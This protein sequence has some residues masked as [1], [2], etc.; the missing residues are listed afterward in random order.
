MKYI[1]TLKID[2]DKKNF[3]VIP[4][5][6]YDNNTRFLHIQLLN[7][8]VPFDITG[9]SVILSGVKE[10]GNPIFNSCDIINSEIG[11]IQAEVTEQM[12]AIPGYIDCEIKIYDG[13]GVLTSKK[14]TIKVTA[15][16]TSREVESSGEFKALT[17]AVNKV[18]SIGNKMDRGESIKVSQIDKNSGKLDQTYM[19]EEFLR[20]MAGNTPIN[21][22]PADGSLTTSKYADESITKNKI[23]KEISLHS[24][25]LIDTRIIQHPDKYSTSNI[26]CHGGKV[27]RTLK[28]EGNPVFDGVDYSIRFTPSESN[29]YVWVADLKNIGLTELEYEN[30]GR[31]LTFSMIYSYEGT[32]PLKLQGRLYYTDGST[33]A[34]DYGSILEIG[35]NKIL[36]VDI[37]SE[38]AITH[39][40]LHVIV[41]NG[42]YLDFSKPMC[43]YGHAINDSLYKDKVQKEIDVINEDILDINSTINHVITSKNWSRYTDGIYDGTGTA[44]INTGDYSY[45]GN[46]VLEDFINAKGNNNWV[47][48]DKGSTTNAT[49]FVQLVIDRDMFRKIQEDYRNGKYLDDAY[50]EMEIIID[51]EEGLLID[52][53]P[54]GRPSNGWVYFRNH[55]I[56]HEGGGKVKYYKKMYIESSYLKNYTFDDFSYMAVYVLCKKNCVQSM[57]IGQYENKYESSINSSY[58]IVNTDNLKDNSV[59]Y[60]KLS[61][62]VQN[63]LAGIGKNSDNFKSKKV[64]YVGDSV[65]WGDGGLNDGYLGV[66][67]ESIRKNMMKSVLIDDVSISGERKIISSPKFYAGKAV[68]VTGINSYIEFDIDSD[69]LHLCLCKDRKNIDAAICELYADDKLIDTFSTYNELKYGTKVKT[70]SS[71]GVQRKFQLGESFTYNHVIKFNG[72]VLTGKLNTAGYGAEFPTGHDYMIIRAYDGD[73]VKHTLFFKTPPAQGTIEATFEYGESITYAKTTVGEVGDRLESGLESYYGDGNVAFDPANAVSLSSGLDFRKVNSK[74]FRVYNFAENK[75]RKFKLIIKAVDPRIIGEVQPSIVF[76]FACSK[77]YEYMNAGIGGFQYNMFNKETGLTSYR[78]FM[79]FEPDIITVLLGT[80]DDWGKA[81]YPI[82]QTRTVPASFLAENSYY[83]ISGK[84]VKNGSNYNVNDRWVN[85]KEFDDYSITLDD[86]VVIDGSISKDDII[87]INKWGN[88]ERYCQ[89]RLIEAYDT[90]TRKIKFNT[91]IDLEKITLDTQIYVKS[92]KKLGEDIDLFIGKVKAYNQINPD[93]YLACMGVPNMNH[94]QLLGYREYLRYM[95][96]KHNIKFIDLYTPTSEY[97][98]SVERTRSYTI[99]STGAN[100]YII[101]SSLNPILRNISVEVDGI[102]IFDGH[103]VRICGGYGYY[104]ND[105]LTNGYKTTATK[106]KFKNPPETGKIITIKGTIERYSSDYC[107]MGNYS[108]KYLYGNEILNSIL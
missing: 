30:I 49:P 20:Q 66:I 102:N 24:M 16:Q 8:S 95:A 69:Q 5:V 31:K 96:R 26:T 35:A 76:N 75:T 106:I 7:N 9:C 59:T 81:E 47:R 56:Q 61:N 87:I 10:D 21:A 79:E 86:L 17:D 71:D 63:I 93:I 82:Y 73:R 44:P 13:E 1:K 107:H 36:T 55:Q 91:P 84:P 89:V 52:C 94:R 103:E 90:S 100:E 19:S 74:A 22:I 51:S 70:F 53:Q 108:G 39:G 4:S 97:Q 60:D 32:K 101:D 28:P 62:G 37:V 50:I 34:V 72:N 42:Y 92:I 12:N 80:N 67:D 57:Y 41:E 3:E 68:R 48:I 6:Q 104:W 43:S 14:F 46:V 33:A 78:K 25:Q 38:K 29:N 2:I 45:A 88:D 23:S 65:T 27:V 40:Y 99:T 77:K 64:A 98:G 15:S 18:T 83:W 58:V 11:F 85:I 105:D 54:L